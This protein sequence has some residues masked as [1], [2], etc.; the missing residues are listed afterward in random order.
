MTTRTRI[1]FLRQ[2]LDEA[3]SKRQDLVT[4]YTVDD[5]RIALGFQKP[6]DESPGRPR[7][8]ERAIPVSARP[9]AAGLAR[10]MRITKEPSDGRGDQP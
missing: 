9:P 5:L 2:I 1:H 4:H 3:R 10:R 7:P 6:P 8:V